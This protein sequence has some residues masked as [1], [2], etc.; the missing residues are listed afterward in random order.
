MRENPDEY[1]PPEEK[2]I[3]FPIFREVNNKYAKRKSTEP[4]LNQNNRNSMTTITFVRIAAIRV[5]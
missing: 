2:I 3:S 1:S 5:V 4:K